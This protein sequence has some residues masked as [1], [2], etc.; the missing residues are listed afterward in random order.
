MKSIPTL[1]TVLLLLFPLIILSQDV[2]TVMTYNILNYPNVTTPAPAVRAAHFREI[3]ESEN[4]DIIIVQELNSANGAN[5]LLNEL[6]ANGVLGKTYNRAP[7]YVGYGTNSLGNMLF[8][9]DDVIDFV[10]QTEIPII[11]SNAGFFSPRASTHY[12]LIVQDVTCFL[13]K[14]PIEVISAHLKASDTMLD[15]DRRLSG[16]YD[17]TDY[18]AG[19]PANSNVILGGDFNFY[20]D[21]DFAYLE[22][23]DATN[24]ITFVDPIGSW[25][26]NNVVHVSKYTQSTMQLDDRF[27]FWFFSSNVQSGANNV[28]YQSGSYETVG[29]V[30]V[31]GMDA[32]SGTAP[33]KT[34]LSEMS[35]HY[36]VVMDIEVAYPYAICP[37]CQAVNGTCTLTINN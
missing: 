24:A 14:T 4:A 21:S 36:P 11:N 5:I 37:A 20:R 18:L 6:N 15:E 34:E 27:D 12:S 16:A 8:Y 33:L 3:V 26:R 25:V 31:L 29:S 17:I 23:L 19:L 2:I 28:T 22:I 13:N 10:S 9:N 30:G 32:L 1:L 35:D 7:G